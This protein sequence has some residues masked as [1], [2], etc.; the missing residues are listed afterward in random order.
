MDVAV[1]QAGQDEAVGQVDDFRTRIGHGAD[2]AVAHLHHPPI[3]DNN[4]RRSPWCLARAVQ[5][6]SGLDQGDG[7]GRG[8]FLGDGGGACEQQAE[9]GGGDD[10]LHGVPPVCDG[11]SHG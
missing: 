7:T 5:Q 2:E 3:T 11:V 9:R 4:R 6:T 8:R 10:R 1:D